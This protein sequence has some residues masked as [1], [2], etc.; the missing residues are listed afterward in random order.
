[1]IF[2]KTKKLIQD[3]SMKFQVPLEILYYFKLLIV[4][5]VFINDK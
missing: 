4:E 5:K 1:M 2:G 3:K